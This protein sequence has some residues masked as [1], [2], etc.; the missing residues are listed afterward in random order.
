MQTKNNVLMA[1][2]EEM[3]LVSNIY[4]PQRDKVSKGAKIRNQYNQVPHLTQETCLGGYR[5]IQ[6][7]TSLLGFSD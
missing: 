4:G 1:I 5:K 2:S 3:Y 6:I 7:Q